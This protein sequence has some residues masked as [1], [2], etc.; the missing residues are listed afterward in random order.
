M[1]PYLLLSLVLILG[2][3]GCQ[4][5]NRPLSIETSTGSLPAATVTLARLTPISTSVATVTPLPTLTPAPTATPL[6]VVSLADKG[7]LLIWDDQAKQYRVLDLNTGSPPQIIQWNPECEWEL[8]PQATLTVCEHQSGQRYLRDIV[9]GVTQDLPIWNADLL[10]WDATGRFLA[11]S[12]GVGDKANFFSYDMTTNVT[13]TLGVSIARQE[14]ESWL[15]SP[16]LSS[17]GQQ[18][19]VVSQFPDPRN[20]SVF[21][22][23]GGSA[24]LRQIGLTEPPATGDLAWSPTSQQ[25]IYGATDV[26]Q[27]V[28]PFP[29]YLFLI[30][31]QTN[32]I[33]ELVKSPKFLFFWLSSLSWSPKGNLIAVGLW[34]P[35][36]QSE[37]QV[38]IID[39]VSPKT[40]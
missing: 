38:C 36:F 19:A 30:D 28:G 1:K 26:E 2:L 5:T 7:L 23:A 15:G 8:L 18:I 16:A 13:Q 37:S 10:A 24:D 34:D 12:Y 40:K 29:N 9:K 22:I 31:K 20:T 3:S 6:P 11:F 32:K 25:I 39:V 27:E 17:S 33:R 21:E 14:Q 35:A 4:T